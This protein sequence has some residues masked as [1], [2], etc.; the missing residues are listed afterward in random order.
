MNDFIIKMKNSWAESDYNA[1]PFPFTDEK[2]SQ[3]FEDAERDGTNPYGWAWYLIEQILIAEGK[4][5]PLPEY[6]HPEGKYT[7]DIHLVKDECYS[8]IPHQVAKQVVALLR[9]KGISYREISEFSEEGFDLNFPMTAVFHGEVCDGMTIRSRVPQK[10]IDRIAE[11]IEEY[12]LEQIAPRDILFEMNPTL[13][14]KYQEIHKYDIYFKLSTEELV[15][16][17]SE[18]DRQWFLDYGIQEM[19]AQGYYDDGAIESVR[20]KIASTLRKSPS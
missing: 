4:M 1:D 7:T 19:K 2:L 6:E 12:D 3:I 14:P 9:T 15:A 17:C 13:D 8:V 10:E 5:E 16:V 20:R 11:E 18:E